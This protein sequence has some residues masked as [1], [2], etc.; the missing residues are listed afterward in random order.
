MKRDPSLPMVAQDSCPRQG[1]TVV[2][3]KQLKAELDLARCG[4]RAGNHASRWRNARGS[5]DNGIGQVE[6]RAVEKVEYLRPKLKIQPLA[7]V[8]DV[9]HGK[10]HRGQ[11]RP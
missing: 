3:P 2:L 8:R 9:K 10:V 6:I 4:G 5:E 11:P 7:N 1:L